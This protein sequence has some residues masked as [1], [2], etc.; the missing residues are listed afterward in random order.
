M[1]K[2]YL[3][4]ISWL[5][6]FAYVSVS[7]CAGT[8]TCS[9]RETLKNAFCPYS[10]RN[11]GIDIADNKAEPSIQLCEPSI[12]KAR[13]FVVGRQDGE[14]RVKKIY[15]DTVSPELAYGDDVIISDGK[16]F[17]N[18][19][20]DRKSMICGWEDVNCSSPF[21][22]VSFEGAAG[23]A[24][25]VTYI[26]TGGLALLLGLK[27]EA[28][29]TTAFTDIVRELSIPFYFEDTAALPGV[30]GTRLT[31]VK[32]DGGDRISIPAGSF[33][34]YHNKTLFQPFTGRLT[35]GLIEPLYRSKN[36][37]LFLTNT[38]LARYAE[39]KN[40][41]S[42]FPE[43]SL[44]NHDDYL[45]TRDRNVVY[46][47]N[48]QG[49]G[50]VDG[51][52][53]TKIQDSAGFLVVTNAEA[54]LKASLNG[55]VIDTVGMGTNIGSLLFVP[56]LE[57]YRVQSEYGK[58]WIDRASVMNIEFEE[59]DERFVALR[60]IPITQ[61]PRGEK[62]VGF[63]FEGEETAISK[64]VKGTDL[65]VIETEHM[66]GYVKGENLSRLERSEG[67]GWAA[68]ENVP[69]LQSPGG[70][71]IGEISSQEALESVAEAHEHSKVKV[72]NS[73]RSGW[74]AKDGL[75][76]VKP[77]R[78]P[79]ALIVSTSR[80][81][82]KFLIRGFVMDDTKVKAVT[83]N[84]QLMDMIP[85]APPDSAY[86]SEEAHAF[87]FSYTLSDGVY[88]STLRVVA[89]DKESKTSELTVALKDDNIATAAT[90]RSDVPAFPHPQ[91][92]AGAP[93][94]G[95]PRL[96]Y[97]LAAGDENKNGIFEAGE[98]IE[99]SV[100]A[101]NSGTG[102][103]HEVRLDMHDA[104]TL[105]LPSFIALGDVSPGQILEKTFTYRLRENISGDHIVRTN[106]SDQRGYAASP[107][108]LK[109]FAASYERP[110]ISIQYAVKVASGDQR[111]A[112]G[113]E[114]ALFVYLKNE[115]GCAKNVSVDI[116]CPKEIVVTAGEKRTN[117]VSLPKG[118]SRELR[119]SIVAPA[120]YAEQADA[121]PFR[122]TLRSP[123]M[124]LEKNIQIP[125]GE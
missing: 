54:D 19:H 122:I 58:G 85:A 55:Q 24:V 109:L 60:D 56:A 87:F 46:V 33:V 14:L 62:I 68:F 31:V 110:N 97:S 53:L 72:K 74:I 118:E 121:I 115:G 75:T 10:I 52:N 67:T 98:N 69:L 100:R 9:N 48:Q 113:E 78:Y 8:N 15:E 37:L 12:M 61:A 16:C 39:A 4:R 112:A 11:Q 107:K 89:V 29:S 91:R 63:L 34:R 82:N 44:L 77:D 111:L 106:L 17:W 101:V 94:E 2:T 76:A 119:L 86:P 36:D 41:L 50:F 81:G 93:E 22:R 116:D 38:P 103:A 3:Q 43:G 20:L 104:A 1:K 92:S 26:A 32:V 42:H 125:L 23:T 21:S 117:I 114:G 105:G 64:K 30:A 40:A 80:E 79:P 27:N 6:I 120:R 73:N 95:F 123:S 47:S 99:F 51:A 84:G 7:G 83:I 18:P 45:V 96:F 13:T 35:G 65:Y 71:K 59:M 28:I 90:V 88:L 49:R 66:R 108:T 124:D 5:M 102:T 57:L 25:L 70:T